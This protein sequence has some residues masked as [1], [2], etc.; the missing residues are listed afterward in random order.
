MAKTGNLYII[1]NTLG[2]ESL[3]DIIPR[4]VTLKAS[5]I[6]HFIVENLKSSRRLLRKMDRQFPI[7]ESMF[8][9]MNKRST[10]QDTMKGL[11]WLIEGHDVGVIS[12]AGCA[13]VADPGADIVSLAHSQKIA[14]IPLVGPSSILLS[15]MGSGFSGQNFSFHGYLPKDRKDRIKTLKIYEFESRK[16]GYTQIFMDTPYRNMNVLEDLLNEL[17]DHT[18]ICIASNIT[19]HN[20]RIR[21]MS[22]EDWR[23]NAYDLSKSPCVFLIG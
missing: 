21:T 22:V 17:A 20:Q 19:L 5:G 10:E 6:R 16:K 15:L 23:E 11:H 8:I 4:E 14:V 13:C 9:E 18:Q 1:P 2:G 12:D 7:D 3:E